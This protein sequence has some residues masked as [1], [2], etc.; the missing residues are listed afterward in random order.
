MVR[1]DAVEDILDLKPEMFTDG[2]LGRIYH[3]FY[4]AYE[5]NVETN[6]I[7][8]LEKLKNEGY[9]SKELHDTCGKL[10]QFSITSVGIKRYAEEV[11]ASYKARMLNKYIS[12]MVINGNNYE[13]AVQGIQCE[14]ERLEKGKKTVGKTLNDIAK[15]YE[16]SYFTDKN[17]P[18]VKLG[19]SKLDEMLFLEGG[20]IVVIGAR[21]S[22]GKSA[23]VT[24]IASN[25]VKQGKRVGFF[26]LEMH[27]KQMFERFIV[28]ESGI[29]LT[30][31]KRAKCFLGDEEI[32]YRKA[33]EK[34]K[35]VENLY[36]STGRKSVADI[37][38]EAKKGH[39]D[40]LIIDYIQLV[41]PDKSYRGNRTAEVGEVSKSIKELAM[42]LNI[43]IIE[44]SQMNRLSEMKDDKEPTMAEL[45]E[46]GDIEQDASVIYLLWNAD[47][48]DRTIKGSKVEKN[49]Q[50]TLGKV[51]FKFNGEYMHFEEC[52]YEKKNAPKKNGFVPVRDDDIPF[53]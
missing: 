41:K 11:I 22:V 34:L 47:P 35:G 37:K 51:H 20:D 17:E 40:I 3:E 46:A 18:V 4:T 24:Q 5:T 9:N 8:I 23:L 30:R 15:E 44:L 19:F 43:P 45:R 53:V 12:S 31:L 39:F 7:L 49:R 13:E 48:N 10:F 1:P 14:M 6:L 33:V 21:P 50:G 38:A 28:S 27:N 36:I 26:N 42:D 52:E 16:S 32:R 29:S 2:L 25:I